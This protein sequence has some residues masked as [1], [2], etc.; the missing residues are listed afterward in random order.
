MEAPGWGEVGFVAS[1]RIVGTVMQQI[2]DECADQLAG[3]PAVG[4]ESDDELM[5]SIDDTPMEGCDS[6]WGGVVG[7]W[8]GVG[9]GGVGH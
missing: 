2:K 9:C 5:K 4:I 7:A 1:F 6:E 3:F 8:G